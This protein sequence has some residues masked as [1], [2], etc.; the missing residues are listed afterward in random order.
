[1][2]GKSYRGSVPVMTQDEAI[3]RDALYCDVATLAGEIGERNLF[4]YDALAAA[5]GFLEATLRAA[6]YVV[7][8]QGYEVGGRIC[9]NIEAEIAGTDRAGEV[10]IVG[11]HYDSVVGSPGANDNATGV[12]AVLALARAFAG[13]RT[14]RTLRFLGF[15]NEEPPWFRTP[16][17]GSLR[18]ARRCGEGGERV[19]AMLSLETI[20]YYADEK[21]SQRYPFPLSSFYPSTGNF[22]AFVGNMASR[23]LVRA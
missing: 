11:G 14:S 7:R 12:A 18:Y 13:K 10:V 2:P 5:A 3:L 23:R 21:G 8:R 9:H 20:G 16:A 6:G 17:M 4:R 15:V 1:M 19:A 22:I